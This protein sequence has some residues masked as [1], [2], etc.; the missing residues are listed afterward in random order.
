MSIVSRAT[1]YLGILLAVFGLLWMGSVW[2]LGVSF[3]QSQCNGGLSPQPVQG[4]GYVPYLVLYVWGWNS[5]L[6]EGFLVALIGSVIL[7]A[8]WFFNFE[9]HQ[10]ARRGAKFAISVLTIVVIVGST[11]LYTSSQILQQQQS[12]NDAMSAILSQCPVRW[13]PELPG[14]NTTQLE[15]VQV[16]S[17][18][19]SEQSKL[20]VEYVGQSLGATQQNLYPSA[21]SEA[22]ISQMVS[23][24]VIS[25]AVEPKSLG[26]Q[27]IPNEIPILYAVFTITSSNSS[28]GVYVLSLPGIC[29]TIPLVVGYSQV[30]Y[31]VISNWWH[32]RNICTSSGQFS[33][34]LVSAN[35]NVATVYTYIPL[36][37][38]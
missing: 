22:N 36:D 24:A 14:P 19:A 1:L 11:S 15:T 35:G 20:C 33:A 17:I 4:C 18:P 7:I 9:S 32:N 2:I 13:P 25:I 5:S 29:P 34:S 8:R 3:T 30:N 21:H 31:T 23:S 28:Q 16:V 26:P 38:Q 10:I 12:S 37:Q 6:A 27:N